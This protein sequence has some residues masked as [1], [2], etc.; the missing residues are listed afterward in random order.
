MW[1]VVVVVEIWNM[2]ISIWTMSLCEKRK[3]CRIACKL[4][5][6]W[7]LVLPTKINYNT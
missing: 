3:W 6:E 7:I 4:N 5:Y 2:V 1:G